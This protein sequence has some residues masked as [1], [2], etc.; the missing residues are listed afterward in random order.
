MV[1]FCLRNKHTTASM[2]TT[3]ITT[4]F[5][6]ATGQQLS[7]ISQCAKD[8]YTALFSGAFSQ[9]DI[10]TYLWQQYDTAVL[11]LDRRDMSKE[12]IMAYDHGAPV[13]FAQLVSGKGPDAPAGNRPLQVSKLCA[14][15]SQ[16][17]T[18][19]A[20]QLLEK[21]MQTGRQRKHDVLWLGVW[22]GDS[23]ALQFYASRGFTV[24]GSAP[25]HIGSATAQ[26]VLLQKKLV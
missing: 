25:L 2:E 3:T 16:R 18:A 7:W 1:Q 6:I 19:A 5:V 15:T 8:L 23:Q 14:L 17:F 11:A 21:A 10:D 12:A 20:E 24:Y 4:G 9:E 22:E 26:Q 13:A